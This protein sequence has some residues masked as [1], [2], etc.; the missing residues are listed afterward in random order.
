VQR[1]GQLRR[2]QHQ[3]EHDALTALRNRVSFRAA[4]RRAFSRETPSAL[5]VVAIRDLDLVNLGHGYLTGDAILV[6]VAATLA[7]RLYRDELLARVDG[8][9]FAIFCPEQSREAIARRARE[10][11]E[12]FG[13]PFSTGDREGR[14]FVAVAAVAGIAMAPGDATS[15]EELLIRAEATAHAALRDPAEAPMFFDELPLGR[16]AP[17]NEG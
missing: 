2:I 4:G 1:R 17:E 7:E 5:I 10:L 3:V 9:A 6:E 16:A 12:I 8:A 14:A 13:T 15:F 11:L